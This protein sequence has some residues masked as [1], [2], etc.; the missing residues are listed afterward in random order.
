[1]PHLSLNYGRVTLQNGVPAVYSVPPYVDFSFFYHN[2]YP[3]LL[4]I[5]LLLIKD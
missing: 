1:M 2:L 5:G 3:I 4:K